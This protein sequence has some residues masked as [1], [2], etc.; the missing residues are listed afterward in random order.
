MTLISQ[1]DWTQLWRVTAVA[2]GVGLIIH[3]CVCLRSPFVVRSSTLACRPVAEPAPYGID[4]R[5]LSAAS[6]PHA[7]V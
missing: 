4:D 6:V 1:L 3:R 7:A 5:C 2:V